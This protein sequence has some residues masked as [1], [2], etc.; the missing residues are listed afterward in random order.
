MTV[1]N[2]RTVLAGVAT[3]GAGGLT[4]AVPN[5]VDAATPLAGRQVA[6]WYR[7]KVGG[8]EITVVTDGTTSMPLPDGY[9][10][11]AARADINAALEADF[12]A[13]DTAIHPYTPVVVNTGSKLV[14]IDTGVGAALFEKTKGAFGQY[15]TNLQAAG[16]DRNAIDTVIISHFHGDHIG[17]LVGLDNKPA[18]PNAEIIVP[19]VEWTF[20]TDESNASRVP[21]PVAGTFANVKRI[22]SALGDKVTR[23]PSS[24]EWA[25]GVT[26]MSTPGH[27]PGHTSYTV[28]SG[29]T[30]VLIQSDVTA[31]AA[32]V[33]L[34][35]PQWQLMFDSDPDV[36]VQ[37][38][39]KFYDAAATDRVLVQG[40]HFAFPSVGYIEKSGNGYRLVP[41]PWSP[42]I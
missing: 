21:K 33:F 2:R 39:R 6:G 3:V 35:N 19:E 14:A 32:S 36:A 31:G 16:I 5:A 30:R 29:N 38:R 34:R 27:S 11:N 4:S 18:F 13:R 7:Y 37:T 20:W 1:M 28:D 24:G 8:F 26:A 42:T 41:A 12:L 10:S 22:F 40:Y 23:K 25:P 15:H 17:G 9:V